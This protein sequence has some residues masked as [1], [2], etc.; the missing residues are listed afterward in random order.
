MARRRETQGERERGGDL[1]GGGMGPTRGSDLEAEKRGAQVTKKKENIMKF[2]GRNTEI[3]APEKRE[4]R[5]AVLFCHFG[6]L[7]EPFG[8]VGILHSSSQK[9]KC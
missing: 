9:T 5:G 2:R 7:L 4:G 8:G 1:A 6:V 3:K